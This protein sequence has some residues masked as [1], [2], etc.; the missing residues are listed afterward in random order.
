VPDAECSGG[1]ENAF[2][3]VG[4][5]AN[6]Y[7][8]TDIDEGELN[9]LMELP[10]FDENGCPFTMN[11]FRA[12]R[13]P[14]EPPACPEEVDVC[15]YAIFPDSFD[16]QC[17]AMSMIGGVR[18]SGTHMS[19]GP[20]PRPYLFTLVVVGLDLV[21]PMHEARF[22]GTFTPGTDGPD[23]VSGIIGGYIVRDEFIGVLQDIPA[24]EYPFPGKDNVIQLIVD[25]YDTYG[26]IENDADLDDDTVM[27]AASV[28]VI[29][30]SVPATI[31]G[32]G[33]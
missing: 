29:I 26:Q 12:T 3:A 8:S 10:G 23:T 22:E 31:V 2:W 24:D 11:Y 4:L 5:L 20:T 6:D 17:R 7:L 1:V 16:E 33:S 32:I 30:D 27:D 18:V 13:V 19:A 28:G 25:M 21:I 9:L 15:S 14:P